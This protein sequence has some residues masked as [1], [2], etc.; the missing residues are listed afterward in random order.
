LA[1][2]RW[3]ASQNAA[4]PPGPELEQGVRQE[5]AYREAAARFVTDVK[6]HY[7]RFMHGSGGRSF[8]QMRA[9]LARI[10][11]VVAPLTVQYQIAG[12]YN[13]KGVV[14]LAAGLPERALADF[15][16]G[17]V[18]DADHLTIYESL[19]YA[20]WATSQNSYGALKYAE[21]GLRKAA[22]LRARPMA[23]PDLSW[24]THLDNLT[25]RLEAQYAYFS[26]LRLEN[27]T[28][29]RRYAEALHRGEPT[30]TEWADTLGFVLMRFAKDRQELAR[31][32]T[33]F[34]AAF[35]SAEA[36]QE[37]ATRRLAER[38]LRELADLR[39]IFEGE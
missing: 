38:H 32:G 7:E 20:L 25:S 22:L 8:P 14:E 12:L 6:P 5:R 13:H 24:T 16:Q 34:Q 10:A 29:A 21:L 17:L 11:D 18:L 4:R 28:T 3:L 19:G 26:A 35:D 39:Q 37:H 31:A 23:A 30:D 15:F 9:E 36:S 27:E 33:L 1:K 2:G